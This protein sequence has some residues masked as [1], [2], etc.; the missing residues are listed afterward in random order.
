MAWTP[1]HVFTSTQC[2]WKTFIA[3]FFYSHIH[4]FCTIKAKM[5][6]NCISTLLFFTWAHTHSSYN[7]KYLSKYIYSK[8]KA[9]LVGGFLFCFSLYAVIAIPLC[10]IHRIDCN[11]F[12]RGVNFNLKSSSSR[13]QISSFIANISMVCDCDAMIQAG[14]VHKKWD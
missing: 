1:V 12:V 13:S 2:F 10:W 14:R 9:I 7:F 5:N 11:T 6:W 8:V 3:L 4:L